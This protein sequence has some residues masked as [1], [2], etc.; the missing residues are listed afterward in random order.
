MTIIHAHIASAVELLQRTVVV[1]RLVPLVAHQIVVRH[2]PLIAVH[3]TAQPAPPSVQRTAASR[4]NRQGRCAV[5]P[6]VHPALLRKHLLRVT[7]ALRVF[8]HSL[9]R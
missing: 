1:V 6:A 3:S 7:V 9:V 4:A 5:R 8:L 2:C